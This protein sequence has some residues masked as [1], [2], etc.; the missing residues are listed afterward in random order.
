M[1]SIQFK[2]LWI[3]FLMILV[4]FKDL[5]IKFLMISVQFKDLFRSNF[6][7]HSLY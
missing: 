5:W 3:K 7:F 1:I 4:Q 2:D 6:K